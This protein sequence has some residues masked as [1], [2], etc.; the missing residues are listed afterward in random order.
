MDFALTMFSFA[1]GTLPVLALL[2]FSSL[3]MQKKAWSGIFF[4]TAGLVVLF[5]GIFNLLNGL[6]AAGIIPP[7]F[8][9]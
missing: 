4:K 3:S 5:F 9:F 8:Y 2:S 1:L 6:S 7:V